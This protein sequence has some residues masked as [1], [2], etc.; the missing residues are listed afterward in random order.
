MCEKAK[1]PRPRVSRAERDRGRDIRVPPAS[2]VPRRQPTEPLWQKKRRRA[3]EEP[4]AQRDLTQIRRWKGRP[5]PER[6]F[7]SA[8][9]AVNQSSREPPAKP[10]PGSPITT[11]RQSRTLDR[12]RPFKAETV[13]ENRAELINC[14]LA[15]PLIRFVEAERVRRSRRFAWRTRHPG[16]A[17]TPDRAASRSLRPHCRLTTAPP[18]SARR[19]SHRI[20]RPNPRARG[21]DFAGVEVIQDSWMRRR[22]PAIAARASP[23]GCSKEVI[24]DQPCQ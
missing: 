13:L 10:A 4:D 9:I 20:R 3:E 2:T 16:N 18:S 8:I 19:A 1:P 12:V 6:R 24:L 11:R 23:G 21:V 17:R 5:L 15:S 14:A 22:L 7:Q